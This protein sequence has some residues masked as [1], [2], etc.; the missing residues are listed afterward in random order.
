MF[1]CF[2]IS[3]FSSMMFSS[4]MFE[5]KVTIDDG[6]DTSCHDHGKINRES[7]SEKEQNITDD[8]ALIHTVF[9]PKR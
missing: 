6:I 8:G 4:I 2:S 1:Y 5:P 9:A 7:D 3:S